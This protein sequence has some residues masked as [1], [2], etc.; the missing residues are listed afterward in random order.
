M[1][2]FDPGAGEPTRWL[3]C[4]TRTTATRWL[5]YLPIGHFRHVRAFACVPEINTWVF[6]DPALDR[7][8]L[9][10]ARGE[11]ARML[12]ADFMRDA[13]VIG[14]PVVK[15]KS[16]V[17]RFGGWCVPA[18]KH[19]VGLRSGALRPDTL[20]RHCLRQGGEVI[21]GAELQP[22]GRPAV[23]TAGSA[24]GIRQDARPARQIA[25]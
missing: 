10:L 2:T 6:Y 9:Q 13:E 19:V 16:L 14:M 20:W 8:T 12:M 15:R 18:I 4:F 5:N 11:A 1:L 22:A 24:S 21:A 7:N 17:P 3:L 23:A 25:G